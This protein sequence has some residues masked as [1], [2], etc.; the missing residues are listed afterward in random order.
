MGLLMEE[1][2]ARC[3]N[4][5]RGRYPRQLFL[6]LAEN[7]RGMQRASEELRDKAT[8]TIGAILPEPL[9]GPHR[10]ATPV[11]VALPD[12]IKTIGGSWNALAS[13]PTAAGNK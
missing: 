11:Q 5:L 3:G 2:H 4:W 8:G 6:M 12:E 13:L 1:A 10:D 7:L 9:P